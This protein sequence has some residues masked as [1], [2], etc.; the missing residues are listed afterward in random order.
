LADQE[1]R[2]ASHMHF[3]A[4]KMERK[5]VEA[6]R[7]PEGDALAGLLSACLRRCSTYQNVIKAVTTT[8]AGLLQR[9]YRGHDLLGVRHGGNIVLFHKADNAFL[10]K[11]HHRA[12]RNATFRQIKA[13]LI[14]HRP[15]R[16]EI[17]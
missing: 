17:S 3:A 4:A 13:E 10:I 11:D 2:H 9:L 15:L 8:Q 5:K 6:A 12:R 16:M 7:D 1:G 14:R